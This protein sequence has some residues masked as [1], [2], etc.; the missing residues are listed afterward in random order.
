MVQV[1]TDSAM[2]DNDQYLETFE[3]FEAQAKQPSWI[4]PLR[5]AGMARFAELGFPTL[6]QEDWRFTNVAPIA[7]LPFKPV[8]QASPASLTP[9]AI[10]E[11]TFG[12]LAATRLVFVNGHHVPELSSVPGPQPTGVIVGSLATALA[13][14]SGLIKEH[15]ARYQQGEDNPFVALNAAFFQDGGLVYVPAG[16]SLDAP[17]HLLFIS[18]GDEPGAASHSRNLIIAEKGSQATVLESYVS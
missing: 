4:Y 6:Q 15:L 3:R 8:F 17:V 11:F 14:D 2:K 7:K 10:A 18:T 12:S 13:G 5:K 9:E 16:K 1:T